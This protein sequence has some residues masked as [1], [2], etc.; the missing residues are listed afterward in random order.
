MDPLRVNS[1]LTIPASELE[2]SAA[3]SGGPGGQN[4]NKVNT[5]VTLRWNL[6]ESRAL[7]FEMRNRLIS[8]LSNKLTV[9][10]ELVISTEE[11]RSQERNLELGLE[12]L[13]EILV[14]A[15]HIPKKRRA[16]KPSLGAKERRIKAKTQ[17]S[18]TKKMRG[19]PFSHE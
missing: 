17:R 6:Y 12:K 16:T 7:S 8:R 9:I 4:V 11:T 15:L 2:F 1:N 5:K 13:R 19:R 18:Q 3:R 10:G 14:Q